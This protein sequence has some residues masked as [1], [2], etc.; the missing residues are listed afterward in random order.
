MPN[1]QG[2]LIPLSK[3]INLWPKHLVLRDEKEK[4]IILL[5]SLMRWGSRSKSPLYMYDARLYAFLH[6]CTHLTVPL[7]ISPPYAIFKVEPHF[8][9]RV[10]W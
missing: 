9:F 8:F 5:R 6:T 1:E 7:T 3:Y 4:K 10:V 2:N